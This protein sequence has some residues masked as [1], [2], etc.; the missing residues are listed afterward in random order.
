M[1]FFMQMVHGWIVLIAAAAFIGTAFWMVQS[2]IS[3]QPGPSTIP[4]DPKPPVPSEAAASTPDEALP[5]TPTTEPEPSPETSSGQPPQTTTPG[6]R[7]DL[8]THSGSGISSD[9][10]LP[11]QTSTGAVPSPPGG[12]PSPLSSS[13]TDSSPTEPPL[14]NDTETPNANLSVSSIE[15][16]PQ[17]RETEVPVAGPEAAVEGDAPVSHDVETTT[18]TKPCRLLP[19]GLRSEQEIQV[20]IGN[21]AELTVPAG[22]AITAPFAG[23]IV[24][25]IS[26]DRTGHGLYL[27]AQ[28]QSMCVLIAGFDAERIAVTEGQTVACNAPLGRAVGEASTQTQ[29]TLY[30]KVMVPEEAQPWWRAASVDP[31]TPVRGWL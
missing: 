9:S 12:Q 26:S 21:L 29:I 22:S 30:I 19:E 24:K 14:P 2:S 13:D 8:Q 6:L 20:G 5:P 23:S 25:R 28:D 16:D 27:L 31:R 11:R 7:P 10:V 3:Y 4:V 17:Y 1:R 18:F 15:E